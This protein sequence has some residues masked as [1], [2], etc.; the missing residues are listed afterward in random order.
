MGDSRQPLD[1]SVLEAEYNIVGEVGG[2]RNAR[3]FTAERRDA[4]SK[5]R[6]DQTGVL[7]E[8]VEPLDGDEGNAVSHLAADIKTLAGQS[9]RRLV[10]IIDGRWLGTHAYAVIRERLGDSTLEQRLAT[11]E[12]FSNPRAAAILREINGLLEWARERAIIHRA[13]TPERVYLEPRTDRVRVAF[14]VEPIPRLQQVQPVDADARTIGRLAMAMMVGQADPATY[15][16]QALAE[17]RPDL[18]K[19]LLAGT[20]LLLDPRSR[21]VDVPSFIALVGMAD[22]LFA[23]ESEADRIRAEVLEEQRVER[24]KLADERAAFDEH[25]EQERAAF[26]LRMEQAQATLA[27]ERV[28][29]DRTMELEREKLA[30]ERAALQKAA[31][32]E[33]ATVVAKREELELAVAKR[34]AEIDTAAAADRARIEQL[35]AEIQHAG[36]LEVEKKRLA[37]LEDLEN[38]D[39]PLDGEEY[40]TPA[41]L[42]PLIEPIEPVQFEDET[43]VARVPESEVVFASAAAIQPDMPVGSQQP[44]STP[45]ANRR[46]VIPAGIAAMIAVAGVATALIAGRTSSPPPVAAPRTGVVAPVAPPPTM[47]SAVPIP[48]G[49]VTIDSMST[50]YVAHRDSVRRRALAAA[51]LKPK[52]VVHDA[53]WRA[54]SA[55]A[56]SIGGQVPGFTPSREPAPERT[57]P[58]SAKP[59]STTPKDSTG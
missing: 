20:E 30:G 47:P 54:D 58:D 15:E 11:G 44:A 41:F 14:A 52:V 34:L 53:Q 18:P 10:P 51:K 2:V 24:A 49:V 33:R 31:E 50:A 39:T 27:G 5:R 42:M 59:A 3:A 17:L 6:D 22:P 56:A 32:A 9:H 12:K 40:A 26:E 19:E 45:T 36:Q 16:G 1:L 46:W 57:R 37:A 35:R 7:I 28:A 48:S 4:S 38:D 29:F 13:V 43:E 55:A 25:M 8:V 21:D 23:G